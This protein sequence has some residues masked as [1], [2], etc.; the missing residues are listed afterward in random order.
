MWQF[1]FSITLSI[2]DNTIIPPPLFAA[3]LGSVRI[4]LNILKAIRINEYMTVEMDSEV[5]TFVSQDTHHIKATA[6]MQRQHFSQYRFTSSDCTRFTVNSDA[7]IACLG[8]IASRQNDGCTMKYVSEGAAF[9]I[10]GVNNE[11]MEK[12]RLRTLEPEEEFIGLNLGDEVS[13]L[14]YTVMK[15]DWLRDALRHLDP[16]CGSTCECESVTFHI[17]PD[18]EFIR[19]SANAELDAWN[20]EYSVRSETLLEFDALTEVNFSYRYSDLALCKKALE[21]SENVSLRTDPSGYL[22]LLFPVEISLTTTYIEFVIAPL[23]TDET[24]MQ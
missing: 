22:G 23:D 20:M 1:S 8:I 10:R 12:C 11:A 13:W 4:L 21:M 14:Q 6:Y 17:S 16:T 15:T 5:L 3:E 2:M 9:E 19:L 18:A 24:S 7:L